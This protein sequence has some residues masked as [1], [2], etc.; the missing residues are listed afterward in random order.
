MQAQPSATCRRFSAA[1]CKGSSAAL[2]CRQPARHPL[3][4]RAPLP[5]SLPHP[6]A[7]AERLAAWAD[8]LDTGGIPTS[9]A[10]SLTAPQWAQHVRTA[11]AQVSPRL[12]VALARRFPAQAGIRLELQR[13]VAQDA[14]EPAVQVWAG[15][16]AV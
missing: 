16:C 10:A 5:G 9:A 6:G 14:G 4:L 1:C 2:P 13:L 15:L 8:P 11:W 3:G 7:E 12:A